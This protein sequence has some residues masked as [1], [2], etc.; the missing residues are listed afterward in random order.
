[1]RDSMERRKRRKADKEGRKEGRREG[2]REGEKSVWG[3]GG[4]KGRKGKEKDIC[5]R[6]SKYISLARVKGPGEA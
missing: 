4:G 3:G 6:F 5:Y 2:G 1:M